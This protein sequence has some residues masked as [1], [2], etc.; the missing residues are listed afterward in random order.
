MRLAHWP[1]SRSVSPQRDHKAGRDFGGA[2]VGASDTG[3]VSASAGYGISAY[4]GAPG[5]HTATLPRV[6]RQ[7]DVDSYRD[8][9][10][11]HASTG[12]PPDGRSDERASYSTEALTAQM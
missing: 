3:A 12:I 8:S 11:I 9:N 2:V 7:L 10:L 1:Y 4:S 6:I 5:A